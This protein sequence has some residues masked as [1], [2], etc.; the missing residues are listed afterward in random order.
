[1]HIRD[2]HV[3]RATKDHLLRHF[4]KQT[5]KQVGTAILST[6]ST[7]DYRKLQQLDADED[8]E[9]SSEESTWSNSQLHIPLS[10]LF[11]F[12]NQTWIAV[13]ERSAHRSFDEELE[14]Y[15]MLDLDAEGED[16]EGLDDMGL[17]DT[18]DSILSIINGFPAEEI[19]RDFRIKDALEYINL[20]HDCGDFPGRFLDAFKLLLK[21]NQTVSCPFMAVRSTGET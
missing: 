7:P 6:L 10:H 13:H 1:M 8:D 17:D 11:D 15:K 4:G 20:R 3:Q 18:V 12:E 14:L 9:D 5:E 21:G 19:W 16:D 2:K